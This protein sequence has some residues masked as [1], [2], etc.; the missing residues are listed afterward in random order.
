M[1]EKKRNKKERS[2][3]V[4]G[5]STNWMKIKEIKGNQSKYDCP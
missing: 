2:C 5:F 3:L 1:S 4:P